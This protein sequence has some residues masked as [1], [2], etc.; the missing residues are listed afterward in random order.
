VD[1]SK[2]LITFSVEGFGQLIGENPV[3]LRCGKN[4]ILAQSAF[5]PGQMTITAASAGLHQA[6]VI[7]KTV[8][9]G[10]DVDMPKDLPVHPSPRPIASSGRLSSSP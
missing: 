8:P 3:K 6:S 2:A 4:I 9:I 1:T 5:R 10:P 7:V